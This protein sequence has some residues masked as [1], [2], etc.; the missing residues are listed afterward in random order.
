MERMVWTDDKLS[1][2]FDALNERLD[3]RF[4]AIDRRFTQF[5]RR[6]DETD[7][8]FSRLEVETGSLRD[9]ILQLHATLFRFCAA[10]VFA[11]IGV[12][13]AILVRGG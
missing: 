2:R 4:D 7:R 3:L 13:G 5:G 1:E 10:I 9:A 8:G 6:F 12:I 11:L